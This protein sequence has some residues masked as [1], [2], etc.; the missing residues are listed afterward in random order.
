MDAPTSRRA[1]RPGCEPDRPRSPEQWPTAIT[2]VAPNEVEIRGFAVDE[3][4]GRLGFSEAI[5]LLLRGELPTPAIGRLFDAVLVASLDHG[6][7]PPSTLAARNVATTGAPLKDAVA[8]GIMGFGTYHGSGIEPALRFLQFGLALTRAGDTYDRAAGR[9]VSDCLDRGETPP[10]FG[11]RI[12]ERDPRAARLCQLSHELDLEGEHCRLLRVV[13]RV[14]NSRPERAS[15]PLPL[16]L[17]GAVAA[18]CGDLGFT[19]EIANGLFIIAR[20]PGLLAHAAEERDRHK[21][22]R[23]IDPKDHWY[24]GPGRRRLPGL[25]K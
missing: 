4:M 21:T 6:V 17:D 9:I 3:L 11:H 5:Y 22:M 24:D 1:R 16:N 10:G 12:H 2:R 18:I 14:L 19:P 15:Q 25:R 20:V 8:A 23:Q 7:S 13:D